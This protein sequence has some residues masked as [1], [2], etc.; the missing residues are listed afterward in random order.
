MR[1]RR[2]PIEVESPEEFGYDRIRCN[3][4]ESSFADAR[5]SELGLRL[6]DLVLMYHDHRGHRGLRE[7]LA[8][9]QRVQPDE[10]LTTVGAAAALFIIATTLLERGDHL[11]V[12]RPNYA[13]NLETPRAIGCDISFLDLKFEKDW[14]LD[15]NELAALLRPTT[16][17]VSLTCPHNPTG[18]VFG[19]EKL[20]A[21]A[22]LCDA[23]GIHLLV[24]ETYREMAYA[25]PLP[26]AV[27][28]S[29][30]VISVSSLSKTYGLPGIR[31]GW[32]ATRDKELYESFL[33]AKEQIFICNSIVDEEIAYQALLRRPTWLPAIRERIDAAFRTTRDWMAAQGDLEWV[34]PR[35][36]VVCFPRVRA[37]ERH[38]IDRFYRVLLEDYATVVGP[39]HWFEQPR[40]SF[41]LGYGWPT[42][43]ALAEGLDNISKALKASVL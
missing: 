42:P 13:T 31:M 20:A 10:V 29:P 17:L 22:S 4:A 21:A 23:Y 26:A 7:L 15:L 9:D 16:K 3:L 36:G 33:A 39:G 14:Q 34:E 8:K 6:D 24:D 18:V 11:V 30:R 1:Y 12:V 41:R 38:D 40:H 28:L 27:G 43:E 35:G 37:P 19:A 32:L 5:L 2:M 25:G